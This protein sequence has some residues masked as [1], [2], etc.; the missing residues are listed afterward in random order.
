MAPAM[1]PGT[2]KSSAGGS[3]SLVISHFS[4]VIC[5]K[6]SVLAGQRAKPL[7]S[8]LN[9]MEQLGGEQ[10][11]QSQN[12]QIPVI[13]DLSVYGTIRYALCSRRHA[14]TFRSTSCIFCRC[15]TDRVDCG[16]FWLIVLQAVVLNHHLNLRGSK[17][18]AAAGP[19]PDVRFP[20]E[21]LPEF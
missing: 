2:V 10:D 21:W 1:N 11:V 19:L 16:Q 5:R 13:P 7:S 14:F 3:L 18:L 6:V 8:L 15:R 20:P 4:L 17:T 12:Q 9:G